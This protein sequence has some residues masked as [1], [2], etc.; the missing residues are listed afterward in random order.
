MLVPWQQRHHHKSSLCCFCSSRSFCILNAQ[1]A[2]T[3]WILLHL[4]RAQMD[5][6]IRKRPASVLVALSLKRRVS[7]IRLCA[8]I[9]AVWPISMSDEGRKGQQK[10]RSDATREVRS[11]IQINCKMKK[12]HKISWLAVLPNGTEHSK[13]NLFS[14]KYATDLS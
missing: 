12:S 3:S 5:S 10:H 6:S 4:R 14:L 7:G 13:T 8:W 11:Q 1:P 9:E 2:C